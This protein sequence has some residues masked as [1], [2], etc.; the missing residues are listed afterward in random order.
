MTE[1]AHALFEFDP[2]RIAAIGLLAALGYAR[3]RDRCDLKTPT[4]KEWDERTE[5]ATP[6]RRATA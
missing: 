6:V 3:A 1:T 5:P 2:D 4:V